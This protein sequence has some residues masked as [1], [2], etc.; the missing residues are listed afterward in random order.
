MTKLNYLIFYV[1]LSNLIALPSSG[2]WVADRDPYPQEESDFALTYL[3]KHK[4]YDYK[5]DQAGNFVCDLTVHEIV[6]VNNDDALSSFN[7]VYIPTGDMIE[8]I[9][10]KSRAITKDGKII[11]LDKSNILEVK[12]EEAESGYRIFAVEG[13]EVGGEIEYQYTKRINGRTFLNEVYQLDAPVNQFQ[14]ELNCPKNLEFEFLTIN[15]TLQVRQLEGSEESNQYAFEAENVPAI[16]SEAFS[17]GDANKRRI[18]FRLA[19]NSATG[20][21]KLNTYSLAGKTIYNNLV[22]LEKNETKVFEKFLKAANVQTSDKWKELARIEHEIK[23]SFYLEENAPDDLQFLFENSFGSKLALAKLFVQ[24]AKK[25]SIEYDIVVTSQRNEK[26]FNPDFEHWNYLTD[27]IIYLPEKD[28]FLAPHDQ[29]YRLGSVPPSYT[30]TTGLFIRP[31]L[32]DDFEYPITRIDYIPEQPYQSN[33]NNLDI[34][35]AFSED[36]ATA[37]LDV[38]RIYT[39]NE[40]NFYKS[41]LLWMDEERKEEMLKDLVDYLADDADIEEV[42]VEEANNEYETWNEPFTVAAKFSSKNYIEVAGNTLLFKLGDLIGAQSELYQEEE[43]KFEIENFN[44]RGYERTIEVEIPDGYKV[45]NADDI[46]I[47]EKVDADGKPVYVFNSSFVLE[48]GLLKVRIDEF[49]DK[50]F[51]PKEDFEAFRKVINAAADWNKVTLVMKE[52]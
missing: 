6:R 36:L 26:K 32:I 20:A 33:M 42:L 43:R 23:Q 25:L 12:D 38:K 16:L 22:A 24:V 18:D 34:K 40:A 14:L 15:D 21:R 48:D 5:Y 1:L 11:T 50:I 45:E 9:D 49:Y 30:A 52:M 3:L 4:T 27:Y 47:D 19:Y 8:L 7:R 41:A 29:V 44:N 39:G 17:G 10:I 2:Q 28:L 35:V 37:N 51:Y 13:A 46:I 31:E